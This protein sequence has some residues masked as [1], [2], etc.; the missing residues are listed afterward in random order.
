MRF[1]NNFKFCAAKKNLIGSLQ[2]CLIL[3]FYLIFKETGVVKFHI[4]MNQGKI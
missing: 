4:Y 3:K 2:L 1:P